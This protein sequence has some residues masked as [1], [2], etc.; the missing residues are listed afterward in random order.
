MRGPL[1][2]PRPARSQ[3]PRAPGADPCAI[4]IVTSSAVVEADAAGVPRSRLSDKEVLAVEC[5]TEDRVR[6]PCQVDAPPRPWPGRPDESRA[7]SLS[8]TSRSQT[9]SAHSLFSTLTSSSP[10]GV[11]DARGARLARSSSSPA[12]CVAFE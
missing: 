8:R 5:S 12:L 3:V 2:R 6:T 1:T 7:R 11:L 10:V 4:R 9:D